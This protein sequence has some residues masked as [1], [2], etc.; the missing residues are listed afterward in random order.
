MEF[1][2]ENHGLVSTIDATSDHGGNNKGPSPKELVLNAM[3]GCTAMDVVSILKKMR[4]KIKHFSMEIEAEKTLEY[5]VHFKSATLIYYVEGP[6]EPEK[7][8]RAVD[9]SLSKYCGVNYMISRSCDMNFKI[10]LNSAKINEGP[11]KF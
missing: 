1:E 8:I 10:F 9:S 5:P 4:Q 11:V 2:C 6:I 3:M 7:L